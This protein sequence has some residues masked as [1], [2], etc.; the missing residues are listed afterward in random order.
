MPA[1]DAATLDALYEFDGVLQGL[2]KDKL[3]GPKQNELLGKLLDRALGSAACKKVAAQVLPKAYKYFEAESDLRDRA[4]AAIFDLIEDPESAVHEVTV[5]SLPSMFEKND[6]TPALNVVEAMGPAILQL[7]AATKDDEPAAATQH[8]FDRAFSIA[9]EA[10][11]KTLPDAIADAGKFGPLW[12]AVSKALGGSKDLL[13]KPE[14][15]KVLI[16]TVEKLASRSTDLKTVFALARFVNSNC[17]GIELKQLIELFKKS[18]TPEVFGVLLEGFRGSA[19]FAALHSKDAT[20]A[21]EICSDL[22][23]EICD[24][25]RGVSAGSRP[26][27]ALWKVLPGLSKY[28]KGNAKAS[29]AALQTSLE[30]L[31]HTLPEETCSLSAEAAEKHD[32]ATICDTLDLNYTVLE[33]SLLT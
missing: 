26:P 17:K 13:G 28:V 15:Q 32:D 29:E 31:K 12:T 22:V 19:L 10:I 9:P 8:C 25:I 30:Y 18:E 2:S 3:P 20:A 23:V 6:G 14:V 27:V 21:G 11:I 33:A 1:E 7:L 24:R 4:W 16:E 5:R